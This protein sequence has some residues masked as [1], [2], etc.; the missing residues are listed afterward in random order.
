M[1]LSVYNISI[2]SSASFCEEGS[3]SESLRRN[4]HKAIG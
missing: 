1:G 4:L 3:F 2:S